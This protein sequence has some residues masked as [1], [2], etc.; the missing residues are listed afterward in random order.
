MS[1]SHF[2]FSE[3][4]PLNAY[5]CAT[6]NTTS[7]ANA[8]NTKPVPTT[9][10]E[11][12]KFTASASSASVAACARA[13]DSISIINGPS[14]IVRVLVCGICAGASSCTTMPA[15]VAYVLVAASALFCVASPMRFIG[16]SIC[17]KR[18]SAA[19]MM[20]AAN[21]AKLIRE[22]TAK[23]S[24]M[25]AKMYAHQPR[26]PSEISSVNQNANTIGTLP[27]ASTVMKCD[28]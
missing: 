6:R 19:M 3:N 2:G 13:R 24:A 8:V 7:A 20:M 4:N 15:S 18:T 14:V 5:G 12:Q 21:A 11:F 27:N 25:P 26:L 1:S 10:T 22:A 28:C 9:K 16:T 17:I 23:P